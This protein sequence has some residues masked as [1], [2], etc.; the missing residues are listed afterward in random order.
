[1]NFREHVIKNRPDFKTSLIQEKL[2]MGGLGL[3]GEA[4]E[5]ADLIKKALFHV[6]NPMHSYELDREK[7]IKEMGDVYWYLEFLC[8]SIGTTQEEVQQAN[9]DKLNKRHPNGWTPESQA[10]KADEK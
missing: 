7:L 5:V 6:K 2:A 3:A 9:I 8:A 1:M 10:R 4:G